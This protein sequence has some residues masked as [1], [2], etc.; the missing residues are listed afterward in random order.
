MLSKLF[1]AF[2]D[3]LGKDFLYGSL[4]PALLFATALAA[5]CVLVVGP[6][7]VT[8]YVLS[9]SATETVAASTVVS[10]GLVAFAFTLSALRRPLQQLWASE[11]SLG[12]LWGPFALLR[13]AHRWHRSVMEGRIQEPVSWAAVLDSFRERAMAVWKKPDKKEAP[14]GERARLRGAAASLPFADG[15]DAVRRELEGLLAAFGRYDCESLREVFRAAQE[16]LL[17]RDE[18]D[19]SRYG[20]MVVA[21]EEAYGGELRATRLGNVTASYESYPARRY[22]IESRAFWPH[23][24]HAADDKARTAIESR[25]LVLDFSLAVASLAVVGAALAAF[26][27]PWLV[28]RPWVWLVVAVTSLGVAAAFY[29]MAVRVAQDLGEQVR[30][31]YDLF[32]LDALED[33][34]RVRPTSFDKVRAAWQQQSQLRIYGAPEQSFDIA[35]KKAS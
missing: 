12:V 22:A 29:S 26:A 18:R 30:A 31:A 21:L 20:D 14:D 7:G 25:R 2:A 23:V 4:L 9:R 16:A 35:G 24:W 27:G 13:R 6:E 19:R 3:G 8:A 11:I 33:L 10:L 32:H 28:Y 34:G 5:G 15:P 1:G 17:D